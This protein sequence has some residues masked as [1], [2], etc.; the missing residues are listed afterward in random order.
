M[1]K[2]ETSQGPTVT[3]KDN[4]EDVPFNIFLQDKRLQG[5]Q[6]CEERNGGF[7]EQC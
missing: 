1:T 5:R 2:T 6:A 3:M 7:G 4:V